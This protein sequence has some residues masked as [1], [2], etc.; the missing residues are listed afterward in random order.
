MAKEAV[1]RARAAMP[2]V[3]IF[4]IRVMDLS[5]VGQREDRPAI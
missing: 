3:M 1:V 5:G 4:L 2:A